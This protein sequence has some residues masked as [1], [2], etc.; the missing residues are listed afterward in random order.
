MFVLR[1][2]SHSFESIP[3]LHHL[4]TTSYQLVS[5]GKLALQYWHPQFFFRTLAGN[6][7][8]RLFEET[9]TTALRTVWGCMVQH[10][11]KSSLLLPAR[12]GRGAFSHHLAA[13]YRTR[14]HLQ[15]YMPPSAVEVW[16]IRCF[17]VRFSGE[18]LTPNFQVAMR[19][20]SAL[21]A[22][23]AT[24]AFVWAFLSKRPRIPP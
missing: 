4:I 19:W 11:T 14:K 6:L 2:G 13:T 3:H 12:Q 22:L 17:L 8:C 20:C 18:D 15:P 7:C 23:S 1:T 24:T 16:C 10:K 21:P 9:N 5:P